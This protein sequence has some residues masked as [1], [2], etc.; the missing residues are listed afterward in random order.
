MK[1]FYL[2]SLMFTLAVAMFAV[3]CAWAADP[4]KLVFA[5]AYAP[6]DHQSQTLVKFG[7]LAEKYS[8]GQLKVSVAVGG[9]LGGERDVAEG[10]QVGTVNGAILGGILQNFDPA[11]SILEFPFLFKNDKHVRAVMEGPVGDKIRARLIAK[12]NI[13]ILYYVMR[14]PRELTTKKPVKSLADIKG[15]KI[16]VPEMQAHLETWRA[17]GATPTPL[18]FTEVYTA[19][20]LGTVDG[21]ENPLG[22]IWANKFFEV[23][24]YLA[25]TDHLVGFMMIVM[26]N[27]T[28]K[29]L[30]A[31]QQKA[32]DQAAKEASRFN[33]QLLTS[34]NADIEKKL[35]AKM[36]VTK[37]NNA[38][39]R[40][41]ARD[42][43]KSFLKYDGFEDLYL[44]I[45][46]AG[47][48]Y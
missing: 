35:F 38:P 40:E 13:R 9:V 29:K 24:E 2:L 10:I 16:R 47:E 48:K 27:D 17:L 44:S 15:M 8:N 5:S 39:W 46:K 21:Q 41:A 1:R 37:I 34:I 22:V 11:M 28:Y 31:D 43:Y 12:T 18:A 4:V 30:D 32:L 42:V 3:P 19:L 45:R 20:Q 33:D 7:E 25:L 36:K 26:N 14:T 23:T 6:V